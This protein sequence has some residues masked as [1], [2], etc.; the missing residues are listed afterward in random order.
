MSAHGKHGFVEGLG[1][2]RSIDRSYSSQKPS[3][4][5]IIQ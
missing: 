4:I 1:L 5:N 2:G 3:A